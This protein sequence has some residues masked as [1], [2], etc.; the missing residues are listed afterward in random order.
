MH[1]FRTVWAGLSNILSRG[2]GS[3]LRKKESVLL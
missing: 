2:N 1:L 3:D